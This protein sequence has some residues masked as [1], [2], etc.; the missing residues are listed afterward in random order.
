MKV[1]LNFSH[2]DMDDSANTIDNQN[3]TV[4]K[5]AEATPIISFGSQIKPAVID[6]R[7]LVVPI[8]PKLGDMFYSD[9]TVFKKLAL[10]NNGQFLTV[11]GKTPVWG[12]GITGPTGP[13]TGA[14]GPIGTTG[15]TGPTGSNA[16]ATGPT[17]PTGAAGSTLSSKVITAT[18]DLTI[19]SGDVAYT[20][21]G[22]T[23]TS[24]IAVG[25]VNGTT[26]PINWGFVDSSKTAGNI[27]LAHDSN[28]YINLNGATLFIVD[29]GASTNQS[30][31]V[32]SFDVDG[33]TLTWAKTGSPTGTFSMLFICY[34]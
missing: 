10:G 15:P 9:G 1:R 16:T 28:Y 5:T 18:R 11:T 24:I 32:K 13:G 30:V 2:N 14:T 29:Q 17:G 23:P 7:H 6:P 20:G 26:L 33:F 25:T 21:V 4:D 31:I 27:G 3:T 19:A 34:K 8:A 22:F 12:A